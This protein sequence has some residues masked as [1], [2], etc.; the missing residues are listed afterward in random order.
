[1]TE[2]KKKYKTSVL[3]GLEEPPNMPLFIMCDTSS[4]PYTY[5]KN[6]LLYQYQLNILNVKVFDTLASKFYGEINPV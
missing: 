6:L 4:I 2:E 1:M 5:T 3:H